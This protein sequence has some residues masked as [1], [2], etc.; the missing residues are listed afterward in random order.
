[1]LQHDVYWYDS[2]GQRQ[3]LLQDCGVDNYLQEY[4]C[5]ST[6]LQQKVI[7]RGCYQGICREVT[8]WIDRQNC[9]DKGLICQN[10]ACQ[11]KDNTPPILYYLAPSGIVTNRQVT[12]SLSTNEKSKC[13][14]GYYDVNFDQMGMEFATTDGLHHTSSITLNSPATYNFYVRC[15]DIS[16]NTNLTSNK[17]SFTYTTQTSPPNP[18]VSVTKDTAPPIIQSSSLLPSGQVNTKQI[19][20]SLKTNE[21][22]NC[23][24]DIADMDFTSMENNFNAD[25]NG[26]SH[27]KTVTLAGAGK[28]IYYVRCQDANGNTNPQSVRIEFEYVNTSQSSPLN[29]T[30]AQPSGTIY[31]KILL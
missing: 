10:G 26:T 11:P 20:L 21:K 22:A 4:Q 2:C 5:S 19:D 1:M 30:D 25:A 28:Y 18:I 9:A 16:G 14:Y 31:Q 15:Q 12:L 3:E 6:M 13:H 24:Y 17:I 8:G 27:Y 7:G 23:R 29:I